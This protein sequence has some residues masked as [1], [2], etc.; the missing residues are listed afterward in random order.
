MEDQT[1]TLF[2]DSLDYDRVMNLGYYFDGGMVVDDE[3]S[4]HLGQY[5]PDTKE[6]LLAIA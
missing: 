5:A 6:A 3:N 1:M 4:T 2:T